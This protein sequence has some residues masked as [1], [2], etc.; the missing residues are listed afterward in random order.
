MKRRPTGFTMIEL[1][2]VILIGSLLTAVSLASFRNVQGRF[3][4]RS[5]KT[6]YATLQQR[7]RSRAVEIG[8]TVIFFVD[9]VGDSAFI[10]SDGVITDVTRFRSELNVDL[11]AS[12]ST[13]FLCMTP[14]GYAD[15][16][17]GSYTG[18]F[19]ATTNSTIRLEFW[20]NADSTSL[21]VLPMG[22]LVGM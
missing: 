12:Q 16:E 14:R 6:M 19:T 10:F 9:T 15:Y 4:V 21:I 13:F 18:L 1:V 20:Q 17:C 8:E 3:A 22:Q 5:A 7:A 2:I 11:R